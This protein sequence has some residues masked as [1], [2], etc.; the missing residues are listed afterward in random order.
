MKF[1]GMLPNRI[2][3]RLPTHMEQLRKIREAYGD[4]VILWRCTNEA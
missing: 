1:L 4:A 2:D 3:K